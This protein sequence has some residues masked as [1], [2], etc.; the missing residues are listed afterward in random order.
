L[1]LALDCVWVHPRYRERGFA[2]HLAQHFINY[3]KQYRIH[4]WP[5]ADQPHPVRLSE[6]GIDV[7]LHAV[8]QSPGG[9]R[10]CESIRNF[11]EHQ[12]NNWNADRTL[13]PAV[14]VGRPRA[15]WAVRRLDNDVA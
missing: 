5:H 14:D 10:F 6:S 9:A 7:T 3:C 4:P 11:F 1:W 12:A 15:L 2:H 13:V 8:L